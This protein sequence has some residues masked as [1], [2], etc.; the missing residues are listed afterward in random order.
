MT[1]ISQW[2]HATCS[3]DNDALMMSLAWSLQGWV[4]L[5]TAVSVWV[6]SERWYLFY[7]PTEST[8]LSSPRHCSKCLSWVWKV[9]LI[10]PS[11]R[12][13]K[14]ELDTAVSV[15]VESESWYLFYHP[16]ESTGLSSPRHCSK[17][18]SWVWTLI[19]ILPS[20]RFYKAE[21]T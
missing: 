18:L 5:G 1:E 8:R 19:L 4:D 10:L 20:H 2:I 6:E 17:C 12:V 21:L 7:H 11:H 16:T 15:W 13:Y 3:Q 14:A 9:I